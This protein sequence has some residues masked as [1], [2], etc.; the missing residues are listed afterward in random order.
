MEIRP[1]RNTKDHNRALHE[2][3]ELW[4]APEGTPKGDRLEVLVALVDADERA[5][6][7]SI[8][9]TRLTP[10][11]RSPESASGWNSRD[12]INVR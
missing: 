2:I 11:A 9:P 8:H 4:G 7:P 12:L 3:E 6:I 1:I 10:F 5:P